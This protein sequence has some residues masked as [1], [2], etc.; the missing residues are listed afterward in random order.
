MR[1]SSATKCCTTATS[2]DVTRS[3]RIARPAR[4]PGSSRSA[5]AIRSLPSS[6]SAVWLSWA[7]ASCSWPARRRTTAYDVPG[8]H[9]GGASRPGVRAA[10]ARADGTAEVSRHGRRPA[11]R[12]RRLDAAIPDERQRDRGEDAVVTGVPRRAHPGAGSR[13]GVGRVGPVSVHDQRD[14][15]GHR[16]AGC[17]DH[18]TRQCAR[19]RSGAEQRVPADESRPRRRCD[20]A[21]PAGVRRPRPSLLQSPGRTRSASIPPRR[22]SGSTASG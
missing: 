8:R 19:A 7:S 22:N 4:T 15:G 20:A 18:R 2:R 13:G 1:R 12:R 17:D 9:M 16:A 6:S 3:R 11:V 21:L 5:S 10:G 14:G